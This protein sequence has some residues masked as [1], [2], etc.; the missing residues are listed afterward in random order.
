MLRFPAHTPGC[1]KG[2]H[3]H[4][5]THSQ[6]G[7]QKSPKSLVFTTLF[8]PSASVLGHYQTCARI[9]F[10]WGESSLLV[11]SGRS[12]AGDLHARRLHFCSSSMSWCYPGLLGM[13]AGTCR[14]WS[15]LL[16]CWTWPSLVAQAPS[17]TWS[18]GNS[19]WGAVPA[20]FITSHSGIPTPSQYF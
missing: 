7:N 5:I 11:V 16:W 17:E 14:A 4:L 9:H 2:G 13:S 20:S 18:E 6:T 3:F 1:R 8:Y 15:H 10:L 19:S 12:R